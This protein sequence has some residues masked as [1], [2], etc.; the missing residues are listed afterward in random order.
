ME[1]VLPNTGHTE[2][3]LWPNVEERKIEGCRGEEWTGKKLAAVWGLSRVRS[4]PGSGLLILR[5]E[6]GILSRVLPCSA[7]PAKLFLVSLLQLHTSLP[8]R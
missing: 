3:S 2:L 5:H 7:E 6:A 4:P 8:D 1:S